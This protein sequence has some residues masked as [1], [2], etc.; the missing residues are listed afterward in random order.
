MIRF[1]TYGNLTNPVN[2]V[3][4]VVQDILILHKKRTLPSWKVRLLTKPKWL[5]SLRFSVF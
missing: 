1:W 3:K 5:I 2:L 4:I